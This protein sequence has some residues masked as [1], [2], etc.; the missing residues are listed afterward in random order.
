AAISKK[1]GGQGKGRAAANPALEAQLAATIA[2]QPMSTQAKAAQA[3]LEAIREEN[4]KKKEAA[5]PATQQVTAAAARAQ[6][7]QTAFDKA[8]AA[9]LK[10]TLDLEKA[11]PST[12]I[13][14]SALP[15]ESV[16]EDSAFTIKLGPEFANDDG[17]LEASVVDE[18]DNRKKAVLG[19]LV[20][21]LRASFSEAQ[22]K[23]KERSEKLSE[24]RETISKRRRQVSPAPPQASAEMAAPAG[25]AGPPAG[26]AA[27]AAAA[28]AASS[29]SRGPGAGGGVGGASGATPGAAATP[30]GSATP[31]GDTTEVARIEALRTKLEAEAAELLETAR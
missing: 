3:L 14:L 29:A 16:V 5:V 13:D 17:A 11:G 21:T 8:Q 1:R 26:G 31:A 28:S 2:A 9:K 23:L 30:T 27:S 19:A 6:R 25:C 18:I 20:H 15:S 7:C 22:S 4:K 24:V 12:T 10:L